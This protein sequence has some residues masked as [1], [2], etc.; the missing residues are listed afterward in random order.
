M[1]RRGTPWAWLQTATDEEKKVYWEQ[2]H[3]KV[4]FKNYDKVKVASAVAQPFEDLAQEISQKGRSEAAV[5]YFNDQIKPQMMKMKEAAPELWKRLGK[6]RWL[7][8]EKGEKIDLGH[9]Y[10]LFTNIIS[11][12]GSS[13]GDDHSGN[14]P[15]VVNDIVLATMLEGEAKEMAQKAAELQSKADT[16]KQ[17][18]QEFLTPFELVE[19][20]PFSF[21]QLAPFLENFTGRPIKTQKRPRVF[22]KPS[23][24]L[25]AI[26]TQSLVLRD[27]KK[28]GSR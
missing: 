26:V 23:D 2:R 6:G 8:M 11:S 1:S 17:G 9:N 5:K 10:P 19:Q 22:A 14:F 18:I 25:K 20:V 7:C 13:W 21:P 16:A 3:A 4:K 28:G 15:Y 12:H 24:E 27:A